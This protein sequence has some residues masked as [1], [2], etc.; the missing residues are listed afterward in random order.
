MQKKI[1]DE[2]NARNVNKDGICLAPSMQ[3]VKR[4]L[5]LH[6]EFSTCESRGLRKPEEPLA[7]LPEKNAR[8]CTICTESGCSCLPRGSSTRRLRT[9]LQRERAGVG[10]GSTRRP[11]ARGFPSATPGLPAGSHGCSAPCRKL[12]TARRPHFLSR[13]AARSPHP[14]SHQEGEG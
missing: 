7:P 6:R 10:S 4:H 8:T 11:A 14:N 1:R 13:L 12:R 9:R 2:Q 5:G 3:L